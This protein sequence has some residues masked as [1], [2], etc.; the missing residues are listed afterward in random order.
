MTVIETGRVVTPDEFLAMPDSIGY[1]LVAGKLVERHVSRESCRVA[2]E[3]ITL[4]NNASRQSGRPVEVYTSELSYKCFE[5]D[6]E[7][8]RRPDVSVIGKARLASV[9]QDARTMP[10]PADLV[11]E[12][13]SPTDLAARVSRKVRL[14]LDNG[15]RMV[16]VVDPEVKMVAIHTPDAPGRILREG[17]EIDLGELLPAFRCRVAEFFAATTAST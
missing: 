2:A 8:F 4:F 7:M 13:L 9:P 6:P 5:D 10:I 11:V 14:Y 1:E 12:V 3:I 16:W 15:F 17:D